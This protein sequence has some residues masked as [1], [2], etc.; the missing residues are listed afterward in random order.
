MWGAK[1]LLLEKKISAKRALLGEPSEMKIIYASNGLAVLSISIPYSPDEK[2]HRQDHQNGEGTSS[3]SKIFRGK[4]AH[5]STPQLGD[6][7]ISKLIQ[8]LDQLPEGLTLLT[9]DGGISHNTVPDQALLEVELGKSFKESV[10][11]KLVRIV[12]EMENIS[13]EFM[14]Y[15]SPDF[16]PSCPTL[17]IGTVRTSEEGVEL[18]ASIRITPSVPREVMTS[19]LNRL[20]NF[21][22]TLGAQVSIADYKSPS[23]TSL[24]SP[25]IKACFEQIK[26]DGRMPMVAT[27]SASNESSIY[28]SRGIE[29]VVMGPGRS[30]GNSHCPNE[31]NSI[32]E[33]EFA[34]RFYKGIVERLCT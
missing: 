3:H 19:W 26:L 17:N 34:T 22:G 25:L 16:E 29:C 4:A 27:K 21:C 14:K 23:M 12:R 28:S 9:V 8:Y 30:T 5:S 6:N 1:N 18:T 7:A 32:E 15:P 33:L 10:A 2:S 24:E 11:L 20:K 31:Q 13:T